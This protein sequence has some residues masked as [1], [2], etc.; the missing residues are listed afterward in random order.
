TVLRIPDHGLDL[1]GFHLSGPG[2]LLVNDI[3]LTPTGNL[4]ISGA[5]SATENGLQALVAEATPDGVLVHQR[6][7]GN[8]RISVLTDAEHA[9]N[10]GYYL[11]G[12]G[13][14]CDELGVEDADMFVAYLT[15]ELTNPQ[16][17]CPPGD[18][19]LESLPIQEWSIS[20]GGEIF[21]EA[22]TEP[23]AAISAPTLTQ[24][25]VTELN[26]PT[27]TADADASSEPATPDGF[28]FTADCSTDS[29]PIIDED[30]TFRFVNPP[31][32]RVVLRL[33]G[34]G[35]EV[36]TEFL[37]V[38]PQMEGSVF[39]NNSRQLTVRADR[40]PAGTTMLDALR[41]VRYRN[42][43]GLLPTDSRTVRGQ[44]EYGCG[45]FSEF[46]AELIFGDMPL[47][48]SLRLDTS[49]C[50]QSSLVLDGS[51]AAASAFLWDDGA[52]DAVRSVAEPGTYTLLREGDCGQRRD[53]FVV[54]AGLP[55]PVP[56]AVPL[57]FLCPGDS[58]AV[59]LTAPD[60]DVYRWN[61]DYLGPQ[62]V[63]GPG[64]RHTVTLANACDSSSLE[65]RLPAAACCRVYHPTA[66][67]PNG[68]GINDHFRPLPDGAGCPGLR[69][70]ELTVYDRW[71]GLVFQTADPSTGWDGRRNDRPAA[72]GGYVY[73][74]RYFD[75]LQQ[76][77]EKGV[78]QLLR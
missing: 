44:I 76:R 25:A 50:G 62:R 15:E 29:L 14:F 55:A 52:Q 67:S 39:G 49:L 35:E 34:L 77:M 68:D 5:V 28:R 70:W 64:V 30:A 60:A 10:G 63:L 4:L 8:A 7:V 51:D 24:V 61:D 46:Q 45:L 47:R 69:D 56:P 57:Q 74:L 42:E 17:V 66:F 26:C 33:E 21:V 27:F 78:L 1:M 58:L 11:A 23:A 73:V 59:D 6:T 65:I 38:S 18:P 13:E 20:F 43:N 12:Y 53:T 2:D 71:G 36:S 22:S 16:E 75:G 41:S 54:T 37:D 48:P 31:P 9:P 72:T 3:E 40:L 32:R 19:D